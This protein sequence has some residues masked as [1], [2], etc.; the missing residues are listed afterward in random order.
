[1]YILVA[2][3]SMMFGVIV[4]SIIVIKFAPIGTFKIDMTD[5]NS[6]AY[7]LEIDDGDHLY[8]GSVIVLRI[9]RNAHLPRK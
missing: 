3:L 5:P 8:K 7:K 4:T 6:H 9:D 1:M 2:I